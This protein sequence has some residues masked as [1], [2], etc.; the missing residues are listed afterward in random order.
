MPEF[1]HVV[2]RLG[3]TTFAMRPDYDATVLSLGYEPPIGVPVECT[4][5]WAWN[6]AEQKVARE[7]RRKA[8]AQ[9]AIPAK[10]GASK[11]RK[12]PAKRAPAKKA[13]ARTRRSGE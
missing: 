3:N 1:V 9:K 10:A 6:A 7:N 4:S 11:A 2:E 12:A 8:A 5:G 13:P